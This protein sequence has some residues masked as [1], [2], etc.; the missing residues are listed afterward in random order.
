MR[1][2][3]V[4][5]TFVRWRCCIRG[6]GD[7]E[8]AVDQDKTKRR[9]VNMACGGGRNSG[10]CP[11]VWSMVYYS[12]VWCAVCVVCAFVVVLPPPFFLLCVAYGLRGCVG[13]GAWARVCV[14]RRQE[15]I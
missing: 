12:V 5:T 9:Q 10:S 8:V 11:S 7:V 2:R 15:R 1:Q 3:P 14:V 4:G 13:V 6:G